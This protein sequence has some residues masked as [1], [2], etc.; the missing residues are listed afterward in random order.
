[1]DRDYIETLRKAYERY[2]A[3]QQK[4]PILT[5]DT[6][7]LNFVTNPG[8]F[9]FI[10]ERIRTVLRQGVFQQQLPQ[11]ETALPER[12][13]VARGQPL[14]EIQ[15]FRDELDKKEGVNTNMYFNYLRL[16]EEIGKLGSEL[17]ELW[18]DEETLK[19]RGYEGK[20]AYKHAQRQHGPKLETGLA[21]TL[22]YLLKLANYANV[23]LESACL[24]EL[25]ERGL[26][27]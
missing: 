9:R 5:I 27:P 6:N 4:I 20:Q 16:S 25:K 17:A 22:T 26:E 7:P 1:M 15:R 18:I 11:F 12:K 13:R 14:A 8:D 24:R 10:V 2:F 3:E 23:D 21:A 19:A